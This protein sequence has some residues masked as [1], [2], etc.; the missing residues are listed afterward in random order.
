MDLA[1]FWER[2]RR[3]VPDRWAHDPLP[4]LTRAAKLLAVV[5]VGLCAGLAGMSAGGRVE[6]PVGPTEVA[7]SIR[8]ALDGRTTVQIPPLGSLEMN[9]HW[10]PVLL[11]ARV[12]EVRTE[13]ARGLIESDAAFEKFTDSIAEQLRN[14]VIVM[15]LR[16]VLLGLVVAFL[17]G[18]V[19]FRSWRRAL[20]GTGS[21]LGG[22]L[23]IGLVAAGTFNPQSV[24]EPRYTGLLANAPQL[25]GDAQSIVQRFGEYRA[26]LAKLV[27][28]VS[29]LYSAT[30]TLPTYEPDP[31]TLRVLHVSDI[32][33]NPV[34]W[35]VIGQVS[36][37]FKVDII[38]DTGDLTDHGTKAETK[39]VDEIEKLDVPYVFVRGNHDSAAT[40][41]AVADQDN[42]I[43]LDDD[44]HE[45]EGLKIYGMGDPR[46]TP[47]KSTRDDNVGAVQLQT[48]AAAFAE[49]LRL[50]QT[51]PDVVVAHDSNMGRPFSGLTPLVLSGHTHRRS[52]SLLPTGTRMFVQG[53][54]GGAG[55]RG[56]EHE[57]PTPVELS[58]LYFNRVTRRLQG[59]DDLQLGGLGLTSAQ[60]ERHLEPDP[61]RAVTPPPQVPTPDPSGKA[62][63]VP[64]GE[65]PPAPDGG[66]PPAPGGDEQPDPAQSTPGSPAATTRR[67]D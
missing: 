7:M 9:S 18:L 41:R 22:M 65:A 49:R 5:A 66:S 57:E 1:G 2:L 23:V 10:G 30:S 52:T 48:D 35:S 62:S 63:P 17:A 33:L 20:F 38:I 53:S 36:E 39:F 64:D 45:I 56:L 16:G 60:I 4:R 11:E 40:Q 24:A 46:F 25:V 29:Q 3:R 43:V 13:Q 34:A 27:G 50:A 58:I 59:W 28:N 51:L 12:T 31:N 8:P 15:V 6:T 37:Q 47:D 19:V 32:H 44:L 61:D 54:T 26:Q 14:G 21:A 42:A 55:L 67:T